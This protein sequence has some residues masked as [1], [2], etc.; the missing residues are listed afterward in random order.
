MN[1]MPRK[2]I[3]PKILLML[4]PFWTPLIPPLGIACIK[5][6]L[7]KEGYDVSI[8]DANQQA[9]I[10]RHYYLY[11]NQLA[12]CVPEKLKGNFLN[13]GHNVL[14]HHCMVFLNGSNRPDHL[15]LIATIV[16]K[17]YFCEISEEQAKVL[18]EIV[19][20]FYEDVEK[21]VLDQL[22]R[23]RPT[24]VGL[25]VYSGN[26][27]ASLYTF[28]LVKKYSSEITTFMGGGIFADQLAVGTPDFS[29]FIENTRYIDKIF[30]GESENLL[31]KYLLDDLAS[32][33][34]VYS[35]ED[36]EGEYLNLTTATPPDFTGLNVQGYPQLATFVSRSCPYQCKFCSET[37]QWGKF[38][39]KDAAQVADELQELYDRYKKQIFMFGDSLLNPFVDQFSEEMIRR[40]LSF[41]WDGYLRADKHVCDP[42]KA[43]KWRQG[44]F[45]RARIGVESGSQRVL[46]MMDKRITTEQIQGSLTSLAQVGIKTSTY[47]V[48]GFP[49]ETEDDFAE[50]LDL[51]EKMKDN[52]WEAEC[53][54]FWY[55]PSA[56]VG[57]DSWFRDNGV[58][59]L[60]PERFSDRFFVRSWVVDGDPKREVIYDRVRRFMEHCTRLGVPNPYT[61]RDIYLADERWKQLHRNAVPMISKFSPKNFIEENKSVESME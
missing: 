38:R 50:T 35:L 58:S 27:P 3:T 16:S 1:P 25:S 17:H 48:I 24:M 55:Y 52:I 36:I 47:W 46:D 19:G 32:N 28:Q 43:L 21:Y 23:F 15:D 54:P 34:K 45:Y 26:L 39:K 2:E 40:G 42:R 44:G 60:Y 56:Q 49:G 41:Y 20:R 12:K 31:L 11:N 33:K 30:V 53:N 5:S 18:D 37:V 8:A 57:S 29:H 13:T 59:L 4:M 61:L 7:Q 10:W 9:D 14:R 22:A 6:H 51:I